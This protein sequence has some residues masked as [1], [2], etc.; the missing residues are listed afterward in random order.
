M[1]K[2][3][4]NKITIVIAFA[5][6]SLIKVH[7]QC[8]EQDIINLKKIAIV[9]G[10]KY[11]K[12][13]GELR[14]PEN[15]ANDISDSLRKV[16]FNVYTYLNTDL[17]TMS[18]QFEDWSSKLKDYDVALFYFSGHGA[19]VNGTNYLFPV[20]ADPKAPSQLSTKTL[21]ANQMLATIESYSNLKYSIVILDACRNNPFTKGWSRDVSEKGLASMSAKGAFIAFAASPGNTA[22]DGDHRNGTYTEAILKYITV[23]NLTIDE[24]FT[25][26]N[27][28]VKKSSVGDQ[29]PFKNSSL[30]SDYC[31]SVTR[32]YKPA[33]KLPGEKFQQPNS[34][35]LLSR[36]EG[37]LFS[38]DTQTGLVSVREAISLNLISSIHSG[39]KHP[40]FIVS[41][42]DNII[43]AADTLN[44]CIKNINLVTKKVDS[45]KL[46]CFPRAMYFSQ[47]G[48]KLYVGGNNEISG[49]I[50]EIETSSGTIRKT[51]PTPFKISS[52]T[53]SSDGRLLYITSKSPSKILC[54]VDLKSQKIQKT[55]KRL[56]LGSQIA[57]SRDNKHL[58]LYGNNEQGFDIINSSDFSLIKT[59]PESATYLTIPNDGKSLFVL[60]ERKLSKI[61]TETNEKLYDY[62]LETRPSGVVTTNDGHGFVWLP[63]EQ[64]FYEF[65]TLD[66]IKLQNAA[67]DLESKFKR[68]REALKTDKSIDEKRISM[69]K[70]KDSCDKK[71]ALTNALHKL[72]VP[73]I[74]KILTDLDNSN[75]EFFET[76]G[77]F[78]NCSS[79]LSDFHDGIRSK[80][81]NKF[82]LS[83]N[84]RFQ[85]VKDEIIMT[86]LDDGVDKEPARK[87]LSIFS[88]N[89]NSTFTSP[90]DPERIIISENTQ[91]IVR[92]FV[93]E[94]FYQRIEELNNEHQRQY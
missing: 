59:I 16:G 24:I 14:N 94:Y 57:I 54:S 78:S 44:Q 64:Y 50:T 31:F 15:D 5:L 12:Y 10:E 40:N 71:L 41:E 34:L 17:K 19:E 3:L 30:G 92:K 49:C 62:N 84:F 38:A 33:N 87:S 75:F 13:Y 69:L 6:C 68:F 90:Q 36:N 20:D 8:N 53:I 88:F 74:Q 65:R 45:I 35:L 79:N 37:N 66:S 47:D 60:N 80:I 77:P 46:N 11:Y 70:R 76:A 89:E 18:A 55:V 72:I 48:K 7:A 73:V 1:N 82:A 85:I 43:Y 58:Y 81:N 2:S 22:F 27:A 42:N 93:K 61:T 32:K 51:I 4:F 28:H 21:S 29:A 83:P 26:V 39:L 91:D 23:P 67:P 86:I 25:K 56:Q 9:F 63:K 52:M